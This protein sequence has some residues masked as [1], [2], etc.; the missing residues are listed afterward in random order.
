LRS[1][2]SDRQKELRRQDKAISEITDLNIRL[3]D[4]NVKAR[5]EARK[6]QIDETAMAFEAIVTI[7]QKGVALAKLRSDASATLSTLQRQEHTLVSL[8]K[9]SSLFSDKLKIAGQ[10]S[11]EDIETFLVRCL[12][13]CQDERLSVESSLSKKLNVKTLFEKV[14]SQELN[15]I[16]SDL[17]VR[18]APDEQF[19]PAFA[20]PE[21]AAR[22]LSVS[23]ESRL[24]N[25]AI[26]GHPKSILS[27][28]NLN[29]AALTLFLSLHLAVEP[30]LPWLVIDDP[31]QSMDEIHTA[32]FAA[33]VRSLTRQGG[34]QVIIAVHERPLFEYLALE[35]NPAYQD[36]RLI[37]IELERLEGFD[38][39]ITPVMKTWDPKSIFH[40]P[41]LA[42]G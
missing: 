42:A 41:E 40:F 26:A 7:V 21:G 22:K 9:S 23:L 38:T 11:S 24:R 4:A 3:P 17:F 31:V 16:W 34:R 35:L 1:T 18:L 8:Q 28:G 29:T 30:I 5:D 2:T 20:F 12:S 10:A 14:S 27:A 39:K 6:S 25:G 32:Q 19:V 15:D 13:K 37:T 36:D 33:L